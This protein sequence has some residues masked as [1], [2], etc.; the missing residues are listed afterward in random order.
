MILLT[1]DRYS[2]TKTMRALIM[3]TNYLYLARAFVPF[4]NAFVPTKVAFLSA[5]RQLD[6]VTLRKEAEDAIA[7]YEKNLKST[8]MTTY[9]LQS[10]IDDLEREQA[11]PSFWDAANQRT[12]VVTQQLSTY[13]RLLQRMEKWKK[14]SGDCRA[15]LEFLQDDSLSSDERELL[16]EELEEQTKILRA[17]S[18]NYELELLLSGPYD[19][20]PARILLTAGAG[21]TEA[22]D[23][24]K[25]LKRMYE[26]H[27]AKMGFQCVIEDEQVGEVVGYKSVEMI[28]TGPN[29]FG[30]FQGE[31]GAHRLVRLSPF[32]ANNK[33]QT[34]FAGVDVAPADLLDSDIV[35]N[36]IQIPDSDLDITTMRSGG[37]GG[38][39]VNKVESA[40]R[41]RHIPTGLQVKCTQ[42]RSQSANREIAMKRLK[43]QLLAVAQE[44]RVK[45][46]NEIRGD[47][48]EASWG[49]QIRNYVLHPYK[50]VKDQRT[51]WETTNTQAFL[52]GE[53][54]DECI[55]AYLRYKADLQS[56][57]IDDA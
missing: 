28:V 39:N 42:E 53:I 43:V 40:V 25:D 18:E 51:G 32:N 47:I 9:Q 13:T 30:W 37:K 50:M 52:D 34:T 26:R 57:E 22:N 21:G 1:K 23:W 46:I 2:A 36:D 20:A 16:L 4:R 54:L 8:G 38:Q 29:A 12:S 24:V 14:W 5:T 10:R 6:F 11:D 31:K 45:E 7:C 3:I 41:I 56:Q 33:R 19:Q 35:L 27:C 15:A 44:Q 49:A 17:D 48:V 55:G